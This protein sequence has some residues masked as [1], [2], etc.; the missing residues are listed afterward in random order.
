M[1]SA[2]SARI[3]DFRVPDT[4][5]E[6]DQWLLWRYESSTKVP[7]TKAGRRASSIDPASWCSYEAALNAWHGNPER[8]TGIGFVFHE[9]DPFVGIDLDD[10]LDENANPKSWARGIVEQFAD[11]YCEISPSGNGLKLWCRGTLPTNVGKVVVGDGGIEMYSR[12]RFFTVTGRTFRAG[13]LQVEDHASDVLDLHAA[14]I[15]ARERRRGRQQPTDNG[16]IPHG[17]QHCTLVS[18]AGT[19]ARRGVCPE[20]IE[21]CLLVIN[22]RQ[23]ERPGPSVNIRQIARSAAV[24]I[25]RR[26]AP[27]S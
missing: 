5:A 19:L 23:C 3:H 9:S 20:A 2:I 18:I 24:W 17:T 1:N 11:T 6:W 26:E 16:Q 25:A 12:V 22:A 10:S 8:W 14:L 21:A 15:E 7:Y 27:G 13:P 4:L